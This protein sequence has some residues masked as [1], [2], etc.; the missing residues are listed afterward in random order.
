MPTTFP[1]TFSPLPAAKIR[2]QPATLS[3]R[4]MLR[5]QNWLETTFTSA[6]ATPARDAPSRLGA[7]QVWL[8]QRAPAWRSRAKTVTC[9]AAAGAVALG[10]AAAKHAVRGSQALRSAGWPGL[11]VPHGAVDWRALRIADWRQQVRAASAAAAIGVAAGGFALAALS[12]PARQ[13]PVV[14]AALPGKVPTAAADA[15]TAKR[16]AAPIVP[17]RETA[18][19]A[20]SAGEVARAPVPFER[21]PPAPIEEMQAWANSAPVRAPPPRRVETLPP[22]DNSFGGAVRQAVNDFARIF[23]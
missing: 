8:G 22:R 7:A 5:P 2:R 1:A 13:A 17:V 20:Q 18:P 6:P 9:L 15:R 10:Y 19:T 16:E 23:R 14:V 3:R 21:P 4:Q 11:H 12:P